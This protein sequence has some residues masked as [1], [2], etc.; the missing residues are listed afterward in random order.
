L[1]INEHSGIMFRICDSSFILLHLNTMRLLTI[2]SILWSVY[3][4][5]AQVTDSSTATKGIGAVLTTKGGYH[6][7]VFIRP[8]S[9]VEFQAIRGYSSHQPTISHFTQTSTQGWFGGAGVIIYG[10]PYWA[11][12]KTE[13]KNVVGSFRLGIKYIRGQMS[14]QGSKEF[15]GYAFGN[16]V[17]EVN[18][19]KVKTDYGE[20]SLGYELIIKKR[21]KID[22]VPIILGDS[23]VESA[24]RFVLPFS[25]I[26]GHT[27]F[28]LASGI[29]LSYLWK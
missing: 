27:G 13:D 8:F 15:E 19:R 10:R 26:G 28:P 22:L 4:S 20:L 24:S 25:A 16:Y 2:L 29:G 17:H 1:S 21:I 3:S 11:K 14:Y 5:I 6:P 9:G 18:E 12:P 7:Y 23:G